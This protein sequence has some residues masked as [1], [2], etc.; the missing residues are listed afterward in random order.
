MTDCIC[1]HN[2][3]CDYH[4]DIAELCPDLSA[5]TT[6]VINRALNRQRKM[7][8]DSHAE[9]S[10]RIIVLETALREFMHFKTYR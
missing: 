8:E 6:R 3:S 7:F 10:A 5:A 2:P 1:T 4:K 9:L